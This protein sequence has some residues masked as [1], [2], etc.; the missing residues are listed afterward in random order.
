MPTRQPSSRTI[1]ASIAP[2]QVQVYESVMVDPRGA[3]TTGLLNGV[4]FAKDNRLLPRGFAKN[5]A[6]PDTAVHGAAATDADFE[7]GRDRVRYSIDAGAAQGAVTVVVKLWYQPI[8]FRW[9][10]N[11]RGY[12]APE[13]Q[14]F[15]RY[16]DAMAR[17]SAVVIAQTQA[18]VR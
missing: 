10:E 7:G 4:R 8:G 9:A 18:T 11:L 14:R 12:K 1:R 16:Y 6:T 13:P 17:D 3:V 2:D 15:V 5:A